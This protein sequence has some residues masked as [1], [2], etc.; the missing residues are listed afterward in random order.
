LGADG[1]PSFPKEE[2]PDALTSFAKQVGPVKEES[3][4][5]DGTEEQVQ[6]TNNMTMEDLY[7]MSPVELD[8]HL[9]EAAERLAEAGVTNL[10][11]EL[12][13]QEALKPAAK[14]QRAAKPLYDFPDDTPRA[15]FERCRQIFKDF[16]KLLL[17]GPLSSLAVLA[18]GLFSVAMI[19]VPWLAIL[20]L[21]RLIRWLIWQ[22]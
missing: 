13:L 14:A 4:K 18:A 8:N 16:L 20:L 22:H 12:I 1:E 10:T 5:P 17:I 11:R 7:R 3:L 19:A 9:Q 2:G 6:P 15:F 21:V